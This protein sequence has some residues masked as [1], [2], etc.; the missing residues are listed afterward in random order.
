MPFGVASWDLSHL[1]TAHPAYS[2]LLSV[3]GYQLSFLQCLKLGGMS[4]WFCMTECFNIY[5]RAAYQLPPILTSSHFPSHSSLFSYICSFSPAPKSFLSVACPSWG[6]LLP[7]QLLCM[8]FTF[9]PCSPK[10]TEQLPQ[11][12]VSV[13]N[14]LSGLESAQIINKIW[15]SQAL[16]T[17]FPCLFH[18]NCLSVTNRER[19][20]FIKEMRTQWEPLAALHTS[21]L[22]FRFCAINAAIVSHISAVAA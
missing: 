2:P 13:F 8:L 4:D 14:T 6:I 11:S 17:A 10:P 19:E 12:C 9:F 15:L 1:S 3:K 18:W 22:V 7:Y 20:R 16:P 5:V 21:L